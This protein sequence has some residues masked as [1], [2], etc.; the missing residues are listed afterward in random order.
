MRYAV[1][2]LW[3]LSWAQTYLH[4][5]TGVAG[6]YSGGC[7]VHTCSGNYYD[8]GG[9]GG[10]YSNNINWIYWTFCPNNSTQ[11]LRMQFTSFDVESGCFPNLMLLLSVLL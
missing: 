10:N 1:L 6:T 3:G 2:L 7:Q 4:P 9:P 5:T 8:N 11:C